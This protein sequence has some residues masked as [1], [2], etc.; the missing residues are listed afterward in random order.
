MRGPLSDPNARTRFSG[1]ET[2]P[3][4]RLWLR[5]AY[6]AVRADAD[7]PSAQTFSK[8]TGLIR[9]GVGKNMVFA[10]RH[11]AKLTDVIVEEDGRFATGTVGD[12][13]FHPR[14]GVDPFM[15]TAATTWLLHWL[16]ASNHAEATTW[17]YAFNHMNSAT[18]DYETLGAPLRDLCARTGR[19]RASAATIKRDAEVF[20]RSYVAREGASSV[21]DQVET[22][23]GE[24]NLIGPA[25]GRSFAFRRGPKPNL[26]DEV[27]LYALTSFWHGLE[28]W[29]GAD[30]GTLGVDQ[31]VHE[32]GSP[33]RIFKLDEDA[34]IDRLVRLEEISG[35]AYLWTDTAGVR[36]VARRERITD[37][38]ERLRSAYSPISSMAAA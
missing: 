15:E 29:R 11:W 38:L 26:P 36:S 34:V 12:F 19:S 28:V 4:R 5:K 14:T 25:A 37:P 13:L 8:D 35:G 20:V 27:F 22:V 18:F 30:A 16:I 7:D 33:G 23:L 2:F 32:P 31:I 9:F 3:L 6:D 10:I 17:Y 24:L 21:D 1:H